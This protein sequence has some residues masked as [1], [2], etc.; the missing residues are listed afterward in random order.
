[1]EITIVCPSFRV[2]RLVGNVL[3][4]STET[5]FTEVRIKN[6]TISSS[7]YVKIMIVE[8]R[9]TCSLMV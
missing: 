7:K 4:L 9:G 2:I 1:M 5:A 6:I 3:L 8:F